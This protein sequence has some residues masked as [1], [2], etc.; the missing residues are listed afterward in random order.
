MFVPAAYADSSDGFT[1]TIYLNVSRAYRAGDKVIGGVNTVNVIVEYASSELE[2]TTDFDG[3][4]KD[5]FPKLKTSGTVVN[6]APGKL[7]FNTLT[8]TPYVFSRDSDVLARLSFRYKKASHTRARVTARITELATETL[9][10]YD[11]LVEHDTFMREGVRVMTE[12]TPDSASGLLLGDADCDG[13]V[14]VADSTSVRR[15]VLWLANGDF[16]TG[17]AD[18]DKDGKVTVVDAT[19]IQKYVTRFPSRWGIG[20]KIV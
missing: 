19:Y 18:V 10:G 20:K 15:H 4:L 13:S 1:Y 11:Q 9:S 6:N 2:L 3:S 5:V 16:V 12:R 14:T 7:G 17:A 8:I